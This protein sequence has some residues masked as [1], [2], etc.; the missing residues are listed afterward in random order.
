MN[1]SDSG[2]FSSLSV[3]SQS[4]GGGNKDEYGTCMPLMIDR[5][6]VTYSS[7]VALQ[8]Y[9]MGYERSDRYRSY[10]LF[11]RSILP[12]RTTRL[13]RTGGWVG[14][15]VFRQVAGWHEAACLRIRPFFLPAGT[16]IR[17]GMRIEERGKERGSVWGRGAHYHRRTKKEDTNTY[18]SIRM[19]NEVAG[20]CAF[21]LFLLSIFARP[22]KT[23]RPTGSAPPWPTSS[24]SFPSPRSTSSS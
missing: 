2:S 24:S 7:A 23:I 4:D 1:I 22:N 3:R 17:G 6:F 15:V 20:N 5:F 19:E 9:T 21:L 16:P 14:R 8:M 12:T 18:M 11:F 10:V 13:G